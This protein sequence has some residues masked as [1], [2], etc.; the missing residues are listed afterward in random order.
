MHFLY[1][2]CGE[3]NIMIVSPKRI[4][5]PSEFNFKPAVFE[6]NKN[7]QI[8]CMDEAGGIL[9]FS[10][11]LLAI[12]QNKDKSQTVEFL[13]DEEEFNLFHIANFKPE[14]I[15]FIVDER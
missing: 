8:T 10:D 14:N 12:K 2:I 11:E 6:E 9:F 4:L 3:I 5:S 7:Y 1:Y 13:Y 15:Q